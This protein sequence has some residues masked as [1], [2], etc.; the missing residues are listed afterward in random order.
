M[1]FGSARQQAPPK[2]WGMEIFMR[3][4]VITLVGFLIVLAKVG[5]TG[6]AATIIWTSTSGGNSTGT[7][8]ATTR[9]EP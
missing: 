1:P 7:P 8:L 6:H 5:Y 4:L 3:K 2:A 9:A